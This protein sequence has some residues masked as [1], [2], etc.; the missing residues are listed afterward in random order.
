MIRLHDKRTLKQKHGSRGKI[1]KLTTLAALTMLGVTSA[2]ASSASAAIQYSI[3]NVIPNG[4]SSYGYGIN[5]NGAVAGEADLVGNVYHAIYYDG[6]VHD[7]NAALGNPFDS[8]S[9][10]V[11]DSG[12]ATGFVYNGTTYYAYV[13]SSS[14]NTAQDLRPLFPAGSI[15]SEGNSINNSGTIVGDF[16]LNGQRRAFRYSGGIVTDLSSLFPIGTNYSYAYVINDSGSIVGEYDTPGVNHAFLYSG[17]TVIDLNP[18]LGNTTDAYSHA[19]NNSNQVVG[20]FDNGGGYHAFLYSGGSATDINNLL[21]GSNGSNARG[22]NDSGTVVG[23]FSS[24]NFTG[25]HAFVYSNGVAQDLNN[26]I[27]PASGWVLNSA[28]AINNSGQITGTG[29][30]GGTARAFVL[31]LQSYSVSGFGTIGN[32]NN[33]ST[34]LFN[35]TNTSNPPNATGTLTFANKNGVNV[36]NAAITSLS[37]NGSS[38][39]FSGQFSRGKGNAPG[40]FVVTIDSSA[41]TFSIALYK[42]NQFSPYFTRSGSLTGGSVSVS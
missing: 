33:R 28:D 7:F 6:A 32:G 26:L 11:N 31:T 8:S 41:Q 14:N 5:N 19:V 15:E 24:L 17:G 3:A 27:D 40:T 13:Y 34:F 20:A 9:Y 39:T 42:P 16:S 21:S 22:I 12:V 30:L 36:Q 2:F 35:A 25:D 23:R 38:A 18:V 4:L 37:V 29:T 10:D 1:R